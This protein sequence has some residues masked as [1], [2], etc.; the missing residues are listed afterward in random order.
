MRALVSSSF[1]MA[2]A[3]HP[4]GFKNIDDPSTFTEI[5]QAIKE[6]ETLNLA[7]QF[8]QV[9]ACAALNLGETS[10][11][12]LLK[13]ESP[14]ATRTR[15]I[16]VWGPERQKATV[17]AIAKFYG[18]SPRLTGIMC[19]NPTV[20]LHVDGG[21]QR[22]REQKTHFSKYASSSSHSSDPEKD[23]H[24]HVSIS[25]ASTLNLNHYNIVNEVWH[26]CS[27][28]WGSKCKIIVCVR[29]LPLITLRPLRWIQFDNKHDRREKDRFN[30]R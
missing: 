10:I 5:D 1:S 13:H 29:K 2:S 12:Q 11:L 14:K 20:P 4:S 26:Y 27:V 15:W 16:S 8:D 22:I 19:T 3:V 7:V 24:E 25:D 9:T 23:G 30:E 28:D 17:Q 21:P 18:F 6:V